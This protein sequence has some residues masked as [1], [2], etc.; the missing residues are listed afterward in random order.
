[1][2][3]FLLLDPAKQFRV[4]APLGSGGAATVFRGV[5][6]DQDLINQHNTFDVAIKK[7]ESEPPFLSFFLSFFLVSLAFFGECG[8]SLSLFFIPSEHPK[9]TNEE[10]KDRFLQEVSIMWSCTF[11]EN[12]VKLVGYALEPNLYIVTRLQEVDLFS[13]VH[14]HP[15]EKI[16]PLLALKLAGYPIFL[17]L[18]W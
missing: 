13:L 15:E 9:F 16:S 12:V 1:M 14:H 8:G 4:E 5:L 3:G 2:P 17:Q 10:N 7:V 6:L 18:L 11:H